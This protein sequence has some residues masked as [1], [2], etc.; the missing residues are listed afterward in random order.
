MVLFLFD[1]TCI[2]QS[3]H[4]FSLGILTI[5]VWRILAKSALH[6][7]LPPTFRLLAQFFRLPRRRFY[8]PATEYKSVPSEFHSS[9]SGGFGLHPIPSVIDLPSNVGVGVEV[10][11][12]G[13][14]VNGVSH[15]IGPNDSPLKTRRG[16][17]VRDAM[18][19]SQ[20]DMPMPVDQE[21]RKR[22]K[23]VK[24]YDVDGMVPIF[25]NG[26]LRLIFFC[27]SSYEGDCICWYCHTFFRCYSI[28]V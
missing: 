15:L 26:E 24:H 6:I 10:G 16:N 11:G 14:G 1:I 8:T 12:I 21:S 9:S 20:G 25:S 18:V 5:F 22:N 23:Q 19:K 13:S 17:G 7:V 27:K 2:F 3:Y 4:C 28:D